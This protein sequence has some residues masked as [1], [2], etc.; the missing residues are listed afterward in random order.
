MTDRLDET[1]GAAA[2]EMN[3]RRF[4][5]T[6]GTGAVVAG[7]GLTTAGCIRKNVQKI[8]PFARRPEDVIPGEPMY[9]ATAFSAGGAVQ[10]LLVENHSGRPTKIEG[11]PRHPTSFGAAAVWAQASAMSLYDGDRSKE[12]AKDAVQSTWAVA[13]AALTELGAAAAT[14]KGKGFA[15]LLQAEPSPTFQALLAMLKGKLPQ[16]AVYRHDELSRAGSRAGAAL[17]GAKGML[18]SFDLTGANVIASFGADFLGAEGETVRHARAYATGRRLAK[19]GDG[20]NRLYAVEATLS[21][22][23]MN[24]DNRLRLQPSQVSAA[25]ASLAGRLARLG[26]TMPA[27][28]TVPAGEPTGNTARI[29]TFLDAVATDLAGAKGKSAVIVGEQQPAAVHALAAAINSALGNVG[30]TLRYFPDGDAPDAGTLSDLAAALSGGQVGQLVIIGGNPVYTSPG[31]MDFAAL[32]KKATTVHVGL[33]FD[34]TAGVAN[35]HI[36]MA[37][38]LESWGDLATEDGTTAIVQ[39]LIEPVF[40]EAWSGIEVLGLLAGAADPSG[41]AAVVSTWKDRLGG[42]NGA[43]WLQALHDG[44]VEGSTLKPAA[45]VFD[46]AGLAGAW[47]AAGAAGMEL[48]FPV[49]GSV[50]DGRY[51]NNAWLQELPDQL[52]KLAWDN[53]ALMSKATASRLGVETGDMLTVTAGGK[54][55]DI[56]AVTVMGVADETLVMSQG[57]GRTSGGRTADGVGFDVS[58]LRTGAAWV[59]GATATAAGGS[60]DLAIV[61]TGDSLTVNGYRR[62]HARV[63][64]KAAYEAEPDFVKSEEIMPAEKLESLW[65]EPN[66][67]GGHQWGMSIDL[68]A[69]IGCNAC[70]VACQSENNIPTVGKEE[71]ANGRE[72]HWIRLD[73]YY[74]GDDDE[75]LPIYQPLPCQQCE[76][77]PCEQVC[78]VAA[79]THSP[80]G[81]N[82][83]AYNRC[84]GTRYCANNCPFKVRRFNFFA[85]NA[86]ADDLMGSSMYM[87]RNPDVTVRFRGVMEKCTYCVQ[88]IN[89][90]RIDAKVDGDGN[91]P[92]NAIVTACQQTCPTQAIVFGNINNPA[93]HVTEARKN[94]RTYTMLAELNLHARTTYQA[95]V[96]NP[97]PALV[98]TAKAAAGAAPS[99]PTPAAAK[100]EGS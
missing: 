78:P 93:S 63:R 2:W 19:A 41:Y 50:G 36:P 44:V 12:P 98:S 76:N 16:M 65:N 22:T 4:L 97:S 89:Q 37:H 45:P 26:V 25:L 70:T 52:S 96:R 86:R 68:N 20:M 33:Y 14:A 79:T 32:M 54:S 29:N 34:E 85:Y 58:P 66:E 43:P 48:M 94:E 57:Y 59:G 100:Q 5:E 56:V 61:Q 28:V 23:G 21:A 27:G 30:K 55:L 64:E 82:D 35:W 42:P 84:I 60:Y 38:R 71:V 73:R 51:A 81:L 92:A 88:R 49:G 67:E 9:Y 95:K 72:L 75:P 15:V 6:V 77:A 7:A 47:S 69:C 18:P 11:N 91:I 24:A 3:R 39:P 13:R 62:P 31:D 53:G 90:A 10:G 83:M 74:D 87:Q 8:V 1:Q 40:G 17:T 99:A 80:E 46:W